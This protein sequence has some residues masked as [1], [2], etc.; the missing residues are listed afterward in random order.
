MDSIKSGFCYG[1][2][3]EMTSMPKFSNSGFNTNWQQAPRSRFTSLLSIMLMLAVAMVPLAGLAQEASN[4]QTYKELLVLFE[5]WREC[6]SPPLLDGAPDYTAETT[7]RRHR[8]LSTYQ[9]RLKSFDIENWPVGQQVDWHLVRAEMNG[10]DFNIRVLQPW[11]RDP[12]FYTSIWT[13][14]SDTPAHE[15]PTHHALVELWTYE[16]PLDPQAEA[17]LSAQLK[18]IS[19]LLQQARINLTGN[20][21]ELWIAGIQ[22]LRDQEAALIELAVT[23]KTNGDDFRAALANARA[24]TTGFI[25]W[26][27]AQ[28]PSK[29]GPSGIGRENYTWQ[30]RN[31][32]LVP[33]SW[34]E[35]VALLQRELDRAV[36]MLVLEE[37]HNRKLPPLVP[38]SSPEEYEQ[39]AEQAVIK[40]SEFLR[41]EEILPQYDYIEPALRAQM[42]QFVPQE[43]RNFFYTVSHHELLALWTHWYHWFDLALMEAQPHPSPIRREALLYNIFDSRSEGMSTGFEE[44]MMHAGLYDDNPRAREVVWIML[45]QRAARGLGS[46]YA[47]A[48]IF[49]MQEARNFHVART[50]RGWM[51]D[52]LD[53]LGFEQL[54][55][56]RQPGY[57]SSYVTGKYL[58]E[59]LMAE[60]GR[61]S[62]EEIVLSDFFG[63]IDQQ[64]VIPVSLIHWQLTGDD[65]QIRSLME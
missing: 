63:K 6:E 55:Y 42:G 9:A 26:L 12:A 14:Q 52:D 5:D 23:T 56:M 48:N 11:V 31:V 40:F 34:E 19:P 60:M 24:E 1:A 33:L 27:E 41:N 62:E 29:T 50:P 32:H 25:E 46:L 57:G 8:E 39:R 53:L 10:M 21:R 17:R 45:A 58:I 37:F 38:I 15:G 4:D 30:L 59:R 3:A 65:K 36:S 47:H 22:N 54:L 43:S 13:A 28:S 20:A 18:T 7:S 49:T 35:E 16:F 64:G 51:R 61:Q 44:M 2:R